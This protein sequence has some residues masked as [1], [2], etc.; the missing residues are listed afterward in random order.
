LPV[1]FALYN[2][3]RRRRLVEA[4]PSIDGLLTMP[5]QDFEQLVGEAYRRHGYRVLERGGLGADG[6][7]DLELRAKDKVVV[8]QCK[9]WKTRTV[10]V[11]L[12][13]ELYGAM[14]GE[15]AH[16][17]IFVSSGSFTPDAIDELA[18]IAVQVNSSVENIGARRLQTVMERVL[19]EIS[20][21]APDRG[22]ESVTIDAGYVKK[23]VGDLAKNADLSRFIL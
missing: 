20:F 22:G 1:P 13:R 23:T 3:A 17:A 19:D 18:A 8:V 4:Q 10:G 16:S 5:W 21:T 15:E 14:V 11:E 9:R 12:V 6:G 2:A 7:I